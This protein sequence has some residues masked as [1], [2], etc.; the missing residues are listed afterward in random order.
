MMYLAPPLCNFRSLNAETQSGCTESLGLVSCDSMAGASPWYRSDD[1]GWGGI[2]Y[3]LT[4]R[5]AERYV[6]IHY[7]RHSRVYER[8]MMKDATDLSLAYC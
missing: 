1:W 3:K 4:R 8:T 7:L 2:R 5:Q 6:S